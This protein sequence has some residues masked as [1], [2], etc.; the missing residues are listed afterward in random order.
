[1]DIHEAT[2][3][4]EAWVRKHIP[5]RTQDLRVKHE[6]MRESPF[7]FLRGTFYRWLQQ[8]PRNCPKQLDAPAVLAVGDLHIENFGTWR[9]AE[10][11]LVWGVND[12]DE[13]CRLPYTQD[14]VRLA[15][16][17]LLAI[18][19]DHLALSPKSAC[20][21]IR[22]GYAR[23]L[24]ARGA[25]VVLAERRRWLRYIAINRLRDP[26]GFWD[27]LTALSTATG[28]VPERTLR[29]AL[30]DRALPFRVVRRLAGVGSLGR[31]RFVA[32]GEWRGGFVAREAKAQVPSA[33]RWINGRTGGAGAGVPLLER[34]VRAPDP[35]FRI[36]DGWV[37]RRLA[38]DC[39]GIDLDTV[40]NDRDELKLLRAMGWETANIHLASARETILRDLKRRNPGWLA[41]AATRM[42]DSVIRDWRDWRR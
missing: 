13:A 2:R 32:L 37:V 38:P 42:V 24:E 35:F 7:V 19:A 33:A 30:P 21:A 22:D 10:G 40:P 29:A 5:V 14:L 1:M 20:G 25:A 8:W 34:A 39:R 23:S 4:Y 36:R 3:S 28:R 15:T 17:A 26:T 12:V 27:K 9:D 16:S 31:P 11:R 41:R 6:R 18:E